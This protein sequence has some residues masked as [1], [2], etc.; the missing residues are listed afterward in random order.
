MTGIAPTIATLFPGGL[1]LRLSAYDG[2]SAGPADSPYTIEL[3]SSRALSYLLTAPGDLGLGR[4]YVAGDIALH[5]AH[6][7][8][9]YEPF[10]LLK[11]HTDFGVPRP[12]QVIELVRALGLRNL[13]PPAPPPQEAQ[14]GGKRHSKSR[15]AAA[16]SH[17]YDLSNDFYRMVLGET[18]TY[19]CAS[20]S[21]ASSVGKTAQV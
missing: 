8:N 16:I 18:M 7:G 2:S 17:H 1:P 13:L 20:S 4:A 5:G 15:D 14:L 12:S 6:P 9:P 19:S 21:V 11:D 3:A 10:S